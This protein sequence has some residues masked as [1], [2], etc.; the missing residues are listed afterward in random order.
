M[1][2]SAG[3]ARRF[4]NPA[5]AD[6]EGAEAYVSHEWRPDRVRERYGWLFT[7]DAMKVP[8]WRQAFDLLT[9]NDA[10]RAFQLDAEPANVR[11]R[12]GR[13]IHG[14]CV[15]MARRLV[16]QGVSLVTVNWH[17]DGHNFWDTHG[18][19]FNR[20]KNDL[21]PPADQALAA[22]I[23]DLDQRGMLDETLVV[24][25]GEFGRK[26]IINKGSAGREHWPFCY[27]GLLAGGGIRGGSIYGAS[28][29]HGMHP[30]LNAVTPLDFAATIYQ[31][32]GI[33]PH[34]TTP[35]RIGRPVR[36][37][38]GEAIADLFG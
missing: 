2:K 35:D 18:N 33:D 38:G 11:D 34:R 22:L 19:N 28:D 10:Q 16:E 21:I 37:S 8:V 31:A 27:S 15:L 13:N 25:V 23:E 5:P 7:Y 1:A 26:P 20:L 3:S 24:W 29:P 14:Q 6:A 12:Y 36:V 32:L 17:N 9:S 30:A 4:H